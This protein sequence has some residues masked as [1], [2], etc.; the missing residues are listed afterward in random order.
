MADELPTIVAEIDALVARI[1]DCVAGFPPERL[2]HRAWWDFAITAIPLDGKNVD[3]LDQMM[4]ARMVE[5]V[6]SIIA[7]VGPRMPSS[8]D[9]SDADWDAL[10]ENVKSLFTRLTGD[11]QMCL[12]ASMRAQDPNLDMELEEFR[13]RAEGLWMNIRGK[14]DQPHETQ[15]LLDLLTAHSDVLIRLFGI[16]APTLVRELGKVLAKH[17]VPEL[18]AASA[19]ALQHDSSTNALIRR[20]RQCR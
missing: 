3:E 4:A 10:K 13:F 7:S 8:E 1:A 6:Q 11:Y 17:I 15:A 12:T 20:Y 2:L 5:Y 14:R 9:F 18:Q 19:P 16:D